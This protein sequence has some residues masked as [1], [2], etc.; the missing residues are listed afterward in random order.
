MPAAARDVILYALLKVPKLEAPILRCEMAEAKADH[1]SNGQDFFTSTRGARR[2]VFL[3]GLEIA[4]GQKN[5]KLKQSLAPSFAFNGPWDK[6]STGVSIAT[7]KT[8]EDGRDLLGVDAT[9]NFRGR[10]PD[11]TAI[12]GGAGGGFHRYTVST[13]FPLAPDA[14]QEVALWSIDHYCLML[15]QYTAQSESKDSLIQRAAAAADAEQTP[16]FRLEMCIGVLPEESIAK[17]DSYDAER[18]RLIAESYQMVS[19]QW[20]SFSLHCEPGHNFSCRTARGLNAFRKDDGYLESITC[21]FEGSL[22]L[23]LGGVALK[24]EFRSP[25]PEKRDQLVIPIAA[26]L[27][28]GEWRIQH[29]KEEP[30]IYD[31][32]H[33]PRLHY[34]ASDPQAGPQRAPVRANAAFYRVV[35]VAKS[36]N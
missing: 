26:D 13:E 29:L 15:W 32:G 3:G 34:E 27:I 2:V 33:E 22:Q 12:R 18:R 19:N 8:M 16:L 7:M 5:A 20:T 6:I 36:G 17:L 14:W 23:T 24:S 1:F 25:A 4:D 31:V 10:Q 21:S 28:P 11:V 9:F 35:E 30:L